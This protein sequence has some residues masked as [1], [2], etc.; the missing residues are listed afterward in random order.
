MLTFNLWSEIALHEFDQ[1]WLFTAQDGT[2]WGH[3]FEV[4]A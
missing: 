3:G 4:G 1:L 2:D